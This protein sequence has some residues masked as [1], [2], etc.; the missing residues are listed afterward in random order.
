MPWCC[1]GVFGLGVL[2]WIFDDMN[3]QCGLENCS[4]VRQHEREKK[5]NVFDTLTHTQTHLQHSCLPCNPANRHRCPPCRFRGHHTEDQCIDLQECHILA[6]SIRCSM[7]TSLY[8]TAHCHC[9]ALDMQLCEKD[10]DKRQKEYHKHMIHLK[11]SLR[12]AQ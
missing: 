8:H 7:C 5:R 2:V 3:M 9:R 6:P 1:F 10:R 11:Y 12:Y 4:S